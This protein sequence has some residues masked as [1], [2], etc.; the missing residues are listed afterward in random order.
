[1]AFLTIDGDPW[2]VYTQG[3][4]LQYAKIGSTER[5]QDGTLRSVRK[6]QFLE[7]L[8]WETSFLTEADAATFLA[9][10]DGDVHDI[11]GDAFGGAVLAA[12]VEVVDTLYVDKAGIGFTLIHTFNLRTT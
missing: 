7:A 2:E 3:A 12:L 5:A 10:D 6:D 11:S 9:Y 1:M 4:R 8:G